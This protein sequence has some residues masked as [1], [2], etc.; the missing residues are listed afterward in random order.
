MRSAY[1]FATRDTRMEL[2][3][4]GYKERLG[5]GDAIAG[6]PMFSSDRAYVAGYEKGIE[7][8]TQE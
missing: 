1:V 6:L 8:G 7:H 4:R 3:S 5:Y 2:L